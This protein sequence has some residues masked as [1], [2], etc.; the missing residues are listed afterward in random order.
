ML[1]AL[2]I[3]CISSVALHHRGHHVER[4]ISQIGGGSS[5]NATT[6]FF[7]HAIL[8]HFDGVQGQKFWK[9]RYYV[10]ETHW[11]GDGCPIFLYIGGEGPQGPPSDRLFMGHLAKKMGALMLA[12]EHRYYG[13]SI[14]V[15]NMSVENLRYLSSSQAL[16]D[17]ARFIEYIREY[18]PFKVDLW[19]TP[20]LK[21][22]SSARTSKLVAFGGSY[23]GSLAAWL[24][25]KYP[26]ALAGSVASSAPVHAENNFLQYADVTGTAFAAR[27][28]GGSLVCSGAIQESVT[29]LHKLVVGTKP[30]GVD[31]RIPPPLRPCAAKHAP[32]GIASPLD[33]ATYQSSLFSS[34]QGT[35]QYNREEPRGATVAQVCSV[36]TNESLG[37]PL[38]RLAAAQALWAPPVDP[39]ARHPPPPPCVLASFSDDTAA[40][41]Q[42]ITFDGEASGR[43]WIWQSCNEFGFFQTTAAAVEHVGM[44]PFWS[45][46]ALDIQAAG[47]AVCKAAFGL[48]RPPPTSETNRRYGGRAMLAQ[49]VTVVNG[50]LDPWHALG[51]VNASDPYFE[52]CFRDDGED[53]ARGDAGC[54]LQ[55]V[56]RSSSVVLIDSTAHCGDMY[57]PGL[58]E[59]DLYCP[60]PSC[61]PDPPSLVAAHGKIEA[62][63]RAYVHGSRRYRGRTGRERD[64][65]MVEGTDRGD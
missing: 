57:A 40:E 8:D 12:L 50:N 39:N 11:C 48:D 21:M 14:P 64:D 22:I 9:Q 16:A 1:S 7:T 18:T 36:L 56:D 61:H 63:V 2:D 60:G 28:V 47:A 51:I 62:N 3:I 20:P 31:P 59:T 54:E 6:H 37:D 43:Q 10:D 32:A 26:A 13:A 45:F 41:L 52:S 23:P 53:I 34:F 38:Q 29:A 42:N 46:T 58:F 27:S 17:L 5:S 49:N 44:S 19:S 55:R 33:L 4:V 35:A 30:A 24:P 25:L 65:P 15:A